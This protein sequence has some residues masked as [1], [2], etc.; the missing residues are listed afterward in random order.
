[1]LSPMYTDGSVIVDRA[2]PQW[3]SRGEQSQSHQSHCHPTTGGSGV[4]PTYYHAVYDV[5]VEKCRDVPFSFGKGGRSPVETG[6]MGGPLYSLVAS[7]SLAP[8]VRRRGGLVDHRDVIKAHQSYK[9][10]TTPKA[11]RKKWE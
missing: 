5:R 1:M 11:L 2:L 9:L 10:Q 8:P 6:V 7:D 3:S 4:K